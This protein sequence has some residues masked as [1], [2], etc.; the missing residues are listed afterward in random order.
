MRPPAAA[1]T[2]S[3]GVNWPKA[4]SPASV[5]GVASHA[6]FDQ[7]RRRRWRVRDDFQVPEGVSQEIDCFSL[8]G[9]RC[10]AFPRRDDRNGVKQNRRFSGPEGSTFDRCR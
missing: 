6:G 2:K 4:M 9:Q 3:S 7:E 8:G 10:A 5:S 1:F